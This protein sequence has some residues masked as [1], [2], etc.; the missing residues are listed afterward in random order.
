MPRD[1]ASS[2]D[3]QQERPGIANWIC[4]FVDGEGCFSVSLIRNT[5]TSSGWQVFPEFVVTQGEK[6]RR[7]LEAIKDYFE[8]GQIYINRRHDNH[9]EPLLR[10]CVRSR[11]DLQEKVIPF[12]RQYPL[13]TAKQEDFEKFVLILQQ[14]SQGEHK[15]FDGL[16]SIANIIQSMNR[17]VPSRFLESSETTRQI[18]T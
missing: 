14:M 7:A 6:S 1:N 9:R 13:R 3:N 8:C 11:Q 16:R 5:T 4:G 17:K 15:N 10:Y 2:A 12:F 18:P